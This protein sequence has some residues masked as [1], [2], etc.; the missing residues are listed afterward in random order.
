MLEDKGDEVFMPTALRAIVRHGRKVL[1]ECPL[2]PNMVFA[3]DTF[4]RMN[5][6][7]A[8]TTMFTFSYYKEQGAFRILTIPDDQMERFRKTV[9]A[10]R[11]D[12]KYYHP[13]EVA[14]QRGDRVRVIGGPLDGYEG[15]L[16]RAKGR[17]QRTLVLDFNALGALGVHV[18]PELIQVIKE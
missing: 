9:E 15:T 12:I 13:D 14:L 7:R 18:S 11:D 17:Q 16:L 2:I 6:L 5:S 3:R 4:R 10:M 8:E 1:E